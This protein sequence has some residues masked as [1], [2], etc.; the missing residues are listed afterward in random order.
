MRFRKVSK[1]QAKWSEDA[2]MHFAALCTIALIGGLVAGAAWLWPAES[3]QPSV[4]TN[5][6]GTSR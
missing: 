1:R 4:H 3:R 2:R 5:S 6:Y